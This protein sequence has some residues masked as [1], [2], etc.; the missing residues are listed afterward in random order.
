MPKPVPFTPDS[1][2]EFISAYPDFKC[3][4]IAFSGGMD[5]HVLLHAFGKIKARLDYL[6]RDQLNV[7]AVHVDHGLND[8]SERWSIH[9]QAI[10]KNYGIDCEVISVNAKHKKGES[11]EAAARDARY[12]A[13]AELMTNNACLFTAHHQ[14]D[15]AET[16]L[17]QLVR[18]SGPAGLASMPAINNFHSGHLARPLLGFSRDQL[19]AYANREKLE[20]IDDPG[21]F[22]TTYDRN[23]IRHNVVPSLKQRWPNVVTT[24]ARSAQHNAEV[25][26]LLDQLA[27]IDLKNVQG[28]EANTLSV[29]SLLL[30]D[31][32]RRNNV[33]RTWIKSLGLPL[34]QTTHLAHINKDVLRARSDAQPSV[35]WTGCVINRYQDQLYAM[36][37][38]VPHDRGL[39]LQW[40]LKSTL[41]IP[42]VGILTAIPATGSG[43]AGLLAGEKPVSVSFRQGG[44]QCQPVGRQHTHELKKLFQEFKIPGW[45][46]ERVPLIYIND[47]LAGIVGFCCCEGFQAKAGEEGVVISLQQTCH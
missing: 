6:R 39:C 14:D 16:L 28:F 3:I 24:I 31:E 42:G 43:F 23:Y 11:P 41:T 30:L 8:E 10:C 5:S 34:P 29:S 36:P 2:F 32:S 25:S 33:I 18:G 9:C 40:D 38:L 12:T 27:E 1:L 17:I 19:Q 46:R 7:T 26:H 45:Q 47:T 4:I 13:F 21:N 22:D 20:W 15:Q 37:P 44:E 35:N